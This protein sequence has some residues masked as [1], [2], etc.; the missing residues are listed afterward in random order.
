WVDSWVIY[1]IGL[2]SML[3][4]KD[5]RRLG[6]LAARTVVIS[7]RRAT[8]PREPVILERIRPLS[9]E[10]I[11]GYAPDD[12]TLALIDQFLG[13]R[14]VLT[15][16]RGHALASVLATA[17][18]ERLHFVGDRQLIEQ[19][20]MAFLARVYVTFMQ[21]AEEG[22]P[23]AIRIEPW[24]VGPPPP[25]PPP[26]PYPYPYPPPPGW[27]PPQYPPPPGYPSYPQPGP[28]VRR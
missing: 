20:P 16:K 27:P 3:L 24:E 10:E 18:A 9:R 1:G 25:M 12:H 17:L 19:Y 21:T 7:E 2:I 5:F 28:P 11:G 8:L 23:G 22:P 26:Y 14:Y 15:H 4:S 13:R 6:D